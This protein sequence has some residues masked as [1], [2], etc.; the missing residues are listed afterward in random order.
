MT[1]KYKHY[2]SNDQQFL[3]LSNKLDEYLRQGMDGKRQDPD[4][5]RTDAH[6]VLSHERELNK[7]YRQ[8]SKLPQETHKGI[9]R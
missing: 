1:D 7:I 2:P 6:Q 9:H 5:R 4:S 3:D 8:A